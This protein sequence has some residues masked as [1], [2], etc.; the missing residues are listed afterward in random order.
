MSPVRLQCGDAALGVILTGMGDDGAKG[1]AAMRQAGAYTIGEDASTAVV[2]GM[3]AA[4]EQLG[5]LCAL[6]P[7]DDIGPRL[8]SIVSE[9]R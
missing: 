9:N 6:L 1:L 8:C 4:A 7:L 5:A 2:F 3:P